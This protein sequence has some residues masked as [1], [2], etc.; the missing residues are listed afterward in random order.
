[1][2]KTKKAAACAMAFTMAFSAVA[3]TGCAKKPK[4]KEGEIVSADS[5]WYTM[6]KSELN[7]DYDYSEYEYLG[8]RTLG[9]VGDYF[10]IEVAGTYKTPADFD[11][12]T[13]SNSDYILYNIEVFDGDGNHVRTIDIT[14]AISNSG[15]MEEVQ[16][17]FNEMLSAGYDD[18]L[19]SEDEDLGGEEVPEDEE[20]DLS[21]AVPEF[22]ASDNYYFDSVSVQGDNLLMMIHFYTPSFDEFLYE[23]VIDPSTGEASY[24]AAEESKPQGFSEEVRHVGNYEVDEYWV[25]DDVEEYYILYVSDADG[26]V[27]EVNLKEALP[28][29]DI[30]WIRGIIM[31]DETKIFVS[32]TPNGST[33][34]SFFTLDLTNG[35]VQKVEGNEYDFL[36][37]YVNGR[38]TYFEDIGNVIL[39]TEGIKTINFDTKELEEVFSWDSCNVNRYDISNLELVSYSEDEII[40]T[41]SAF[42][43]SS[44]FSMVSLDTPQIITL[45]RAESNPNA[46]K[47]ILTAASANGIDY[48]MSEAVCIFNESNPDFFIRFDTQYETDKH[49]D[50]VDY[51]DEQAYQEAFDAAS[52]ELGNRL[53]VDIMAGEGPDIIFDASS[54][55]Q[56]NNDDYLIDLS[57]RLNTDGLFGNVIEAAKV[58]GKLYQIPLSF[59]AS[60]IITF[61][62]N[63]D[64]GQVGFTFDQYAVFVDEVCNGV[65]PIGK[66]QTEFFILCM[67]A[68]SEEFI[69][70]DGKVDYD[71]ETFRALAEYVN[72][73]VTAPI[74][75][76]D[77]DGEMMMVTD[78]LAD[79]GAIA[80]EYGS[81]L[82]LLS[83]I[84]AET[85]DAV[86]LGLPSIDGR[87]AMISVDCSVA[88]SAQA[89]DI[90]GC[91]SFVETLT[92]AQ[93]QEY[94]SDAS[95]GTPISIAAFESSAQRSVDNYNNMVEFYRSTASAY[96]LEMFGYPTEEIDSSVISRY[97]DMINSC[98]SV[99]ATD[100]AVSAIVR[101]EMPAYF[102]GQKTIEDVI[103]I[104]EDRVQTFLDE[105]A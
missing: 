33:E 5:T 47:T 43:F 53:T 63:V 35:N 71:N 19:M 44:A 17:L 89:V 23:L 28:D 46:G 24:S 82:Y 93:I 20:A 21:D 64:A 62:D 51:T 9:K 45:R 36:Q 68:M 97:E 99:S 69:T 18:S 42:R 77:E 22:D 92:S 49:M 96:E 81:F 50:G 74:E 104:M 84:G 41:G 26:A 60:G 14:E 40:L 65:D 76:S 11:Y 85:N 72:A 4:A 90:D 66:D 79:S 56:L 58:D 105:R 16:P 7:L 2:L 31:L 83:A 70:D 25:Y 27:C 98:Y 6:T 29:E 73:N 61:Q 88:I 87:G 48:A 78:S 37:D 39:D 101:E 12:E 30:Y 13:D 86:V 95:I 1:M 34:M 3:A 52:I 59:G 10:L 102:S 67:N 80:F 38:I 8:S 57:D 75:V 94:Y 100:P 15:I 55:S 103:S 32:Y 54:L 91:W